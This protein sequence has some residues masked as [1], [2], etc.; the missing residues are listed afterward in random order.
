[1]NY[2]EFKEFVAGNIKAYLPETYQDADVQIR[3]VTKN[4]NRK[5]DGLVVMLPEQNMSPTIYLDSFYE[6]YVA[7]RQMEEIMGS[8]AEHR[9]A[10]DIGQ[11]FPVKKFL[12][13][14]EVKDAIIFQVVGAEANRDRLR[15]MPHR[16]EKDMALIYQ[17]LLKK[18]EDGHAAISINND[19]MERMGIEEGMLHDAAM[20]NTPWELPVILQ[21][22]ST[23]IRE[24]MR[25]DFMGFN[26]DEIT[27]DDGLKEFLEY[28]LEESMEEMEREHIPMY[29]L[30]NEDK[31]D[32][33]ATLFYPE[34]QEQVAEQMGGDY[35]VLPSSV[36]EV[37]IIP[38]NGEAD[39]RELRATVNDINVT[40]LPPD[41]VLTGE[42]YSYDKESRQLMFASE[43][44]ERSHAA[45]KAEEKKPS[46][47]DTLKAKK[48]EAMKNVPMGKM[49]SPELEL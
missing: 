43:K 1:M 49:N 25:K 22:M 7:G 48:E 27:E 20:E 41:E 30:S 38:D 14:E 5:R 36:H 13:F 34:V 23:V 9:E 18:G 6:Q 3:E 21:P 40:Q 31:L 39:Y 35:F 29:V 4:N 15:D 19:M 26:L 10:H 46:I 28:L 32:G 47:M 37:L 16:I 44:A 17:I 42:V 8:L 2:Q 45:E 11:N 12:N 24:M 33:A